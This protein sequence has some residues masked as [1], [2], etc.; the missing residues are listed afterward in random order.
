MRLT[1]LLGRAVVSESGRRLGRV[2]DVR[3]QLEDGRLRVT[4][5]CA[6][7]AGILERYGVGTRGSG[8]PGRAKIH[9]HQTISWDRVVRVGPTI[10]VR[11]E[12]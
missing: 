9:G 6:G 12:P 1:E 10:I 8:G 5:I 2:H 4:G 11:D 3:G 7:D